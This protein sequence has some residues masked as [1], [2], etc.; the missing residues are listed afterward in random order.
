MRQLALALEVA[1]GHGIIHRDL[2]PANILLNA[3]GEP[4]ITDFEL[5]R[6]LTQT[7][8]RLTAS[9]AILGTPAYMSPEQ[10]EG[11]TEEIGA[12]ADIYGLGVILYELL[13]GT[14]PFRGSMASVLAQIVSAEPELPSRLRPDLDSRLEAM[15]MKALSRNASD[16]YGSM[17]EFAT[18]LA[19]YLDSDNRPVTPSNRLAP[20]RTSEA[21]RTP[22]GAVA[23]TLSPS[24]LSTMPAASRSRRRW[25]V[26]ALGLLA[27]VA[28]LSGIIYIR[29]HDSDGKGKKPAEVSPATSAAPATQ[30]EAEQ[31]KPL[32]TGKFQKGLV[33]DVIE[34]KP[35]SDTFMRVSYRIRNPTSEPI[36][37]SITGVLFT[38]AMYYVEEGGQ[39]KV[40]VVKQGTVFLASDIGGT[41]KLGP[42]ES[43]EY[44]AKFGRP[45]DGIKHLTFYFEHAEPIEDVPV[46][47]DMKSGGQ[48][49]KPAEGARGTLRVRN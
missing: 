26:V 36:A 33:I 40:G 42:G 2:K 5:A 21:A 49:A 9:G 12:A 24:P 17:G 1:H 8:E 46:P 29:I 13:T 18:A 31:G 14:I 15:V 19:A 7:G 30:K 11:R 4:V 16:R 47:A 10:V 34:L 3:A 23:A 45:H 22:V 35:T 25:V 38:P 28:V 41:I 27:V 6:R 39:F 20:I 43:K 44:W 32:G 37:I 48:E